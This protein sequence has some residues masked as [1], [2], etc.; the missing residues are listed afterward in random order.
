MRKR[1]IRK[2]RGESANLLKFTKWPFIHQRCTVGGWI[3]LSDLK[4]DLK[5]DPALRPFVPGSATHSHRQRIFKLHLLSREIS[6]SLSANAKQSSSAA[7][8]EHKESECRKLLHTPILTTEMVRQ[9]S[10]RQV[11]QRS[12]RA[13]EVMKSDQ[14]WRPPTRTQTSRTSRKDY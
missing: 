9:Y 2:G 3:N 12:A 14:E 5:G 7:L 4:G 1:K 11:A 6:V 8:L 13:P 10:R